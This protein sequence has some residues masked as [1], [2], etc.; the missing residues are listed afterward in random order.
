M[1]MSGLLGA[2]LMGRER[3][4]A[5]SPCGLLAMTQPLSLRAK[6]SNLADSVETG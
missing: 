1:G 3:R 5:S 4:I 2:D 6:R